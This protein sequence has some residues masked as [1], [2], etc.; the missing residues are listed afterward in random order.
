MQ[1]SP[2]PAKDVSTESTEQAFMK[3]RLAELASRVDQEG[4]RVEASC[5]N[6]RAIGITG[7]G[8]S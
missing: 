4:K 2:K 7:G 8:P 6:V 3:S 1:G 5:R